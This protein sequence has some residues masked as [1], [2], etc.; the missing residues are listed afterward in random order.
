MSDTELAVEKPQSDQ[1]LLTVTMETI[2]SLKAKAEQVTLD[3]VVRHDDRIEIK[4]PAA[5]I[6]DKAGLKIVKETRMFAVK[7]RTTCEKE[8]KVIKEDAL[9]ECQRID[10]SRQSHV[11]AIVAIEEPL[12]ALEKAVEN[13]LDRLA[14]EKAQRIWEARKSMLINV[15]AL[16]GEINEDLIRKMDEDAFNRQVIF[17]SAE[18]A[19]KFKEE[20]EAARIKAEQEAEA[21][22]LREANRIAAEELAAQQKKFAEEQAEAARLKKI[23]DDRQQ[24]IR[25]EHDRKMREQQ[26]AI[27][28]ERA[29]SARLLKVEQDKLAAAKAEHDRAVEAERVRLEADR[30]AE[31]NRQEAER[32]KIAEQQRKQE[33]TARL[34][35]E[36]FDRL[37]MEK[38]RHEN[39]IAEREQIQALEALRRE[40]QEMLGAYAGVRQIRQ[41][42]QWHLDAAKEIQDQ[43][44]AHVGE[45]VSVDMIAEIIRKHDPAE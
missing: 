35:R 25:D 32:Q 26:A 44:V 8:H 45:S 30:L 9:R 31:E 11:A 17:V 33:E 27:D 6:A 37:E 21:A 42:A 1:V 3:G 40:S 24:A 15:G 14:E 12:L 5:M 41:V 18:K 39:E 38:V 36:E 34:Q 4:D 43:M 19:R 29:E 22:R 23:E 7:Q 2:Q 28:A 13:E 10:K 20:Q 16:E